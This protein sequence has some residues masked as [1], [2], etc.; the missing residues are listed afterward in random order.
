M[1]LDSLL[2]L[3]V[4]ELLLQLL[5]PVSVKMEGLWTKDASRHPGID[6]RRVELRTRMHVS[7]VLQSWN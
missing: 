5:L 6:C 1:L 2:V 7:V 3:L 4:E